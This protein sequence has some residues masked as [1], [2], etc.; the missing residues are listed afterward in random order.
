MG[1]FCTRKLTFSSRKLVLFVKKC[2]ST[3]NAR[4]LSPFGMTKKSFCALARIFW[5]WTRFWDFF[6]LQKAFGLLHAKKSQKQPSG[7]KPGCSTNM[8][9]SFLMLIL[10]C[11]STLKY[12]IE[13]C[14]AN[15]GA[16][17]IS[18]TSSC[19]ILV[20]LLYSPFDRR[21]CHH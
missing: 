15:N 19:I 2:H 18:V 13:G 17:M 12:T 21:F 1:N 16:A 11:I 5:P 10:S 6:G 14:V 20:I 9:L 8:F 3:F 4:H 7:Q